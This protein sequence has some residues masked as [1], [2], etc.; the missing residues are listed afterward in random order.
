MSHKEKKYLANKEA[1]QA[2]NGIKKLL[3]LRTKT[4]LIEL[5]WNYSVQITDLQ[6]ISKQL[7]E[8]NKTLKGE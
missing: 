2:F 3:K 4:E 1:Q 7:L 6:N 8:E 5:V